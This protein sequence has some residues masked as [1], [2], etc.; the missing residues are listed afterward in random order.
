[1]TNTAKKT[2]TPTTEIVREG[3]YVAE[4]DVTLIETDGG[5]SPYLSLV[6]AERIEA[7][8]LALKRGDIAAARQLG[9]RVYELR[10][11]GA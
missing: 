8:S 7:V 1:M 11:V 4:V 2:E 6:D 10:E 9:G 5:W 3:R